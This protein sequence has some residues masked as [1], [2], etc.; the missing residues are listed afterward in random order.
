MAARFRTDWQV[1]D[2]IE[3]WLRQHVDELTAIVRDQGW[4]WNDI[5]RALHSA[6]IEYRTGRP[7]SAAI[8]RKKAVVARTRLALHKAPSDP[9]ALA[10]RDALSGLGGKIGQVVIN[11]PGSGV[12]SAVPEAQLL[13]PV[14]EPVPVTHGLYGPKEHRTSASVGATSPH[15]S[16][17]DEAEDVPTFETASIIGWTGSKQPPKSAADPKMTPSAPAAKQDADEV[18]KRFLGKAQFSTARD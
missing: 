8:L 12:V 14:S 11:M 13:R 17:E 16:T 4:S 10:L 1:G 3:T 18:M 7:W 2:R 15:Q 5:G 9:M 6:G